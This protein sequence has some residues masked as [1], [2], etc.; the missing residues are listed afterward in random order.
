MEMSVC[1]QEFEPILVFETF[2]IRCCFFESFMLVASI[3][4]CHFTR[5][6][7]S[8]CADV[9]GSVRERYSVRY[10]CLSFISSCP[11]IRI[12]DRISLV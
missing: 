10:I 11:D 4:R 8:R 2:W 6:D 7:V 12:L 9:F 5:I 3:A 1:D